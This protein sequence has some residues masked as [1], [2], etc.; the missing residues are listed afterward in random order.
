MNMRS[1]SLRHIS[2]ITLTLA[3][4]LGACGDDAGTFAGVDLAEIRV[5]PRE[6]TFSQVDIGQSDA[7]VVTVENLGGEQLIISDFSWTGSTADFS[8]NGL[9]GL[10]V[11]GNEIATFTINYAPTDEVVDDGVLSIESN[12]GR[13]SV[14]VTTIGQGSAL[15]TEPAAIDLIAD[16]I[17]ETVAQNVRVFNTGNQVYTLT[18][19]SLITGSADFNM[20]LLDAEVPVEI[21]PN[22]EVTVQIIFAPSNGGI[23]EGNLLLEHNADN[24]V[25]GGTIVPI[26]GSLRTPQIQV[27]PNFVEFE[28]VPP[29]ETRIETAVV[30]NV[31][32]STLEIRDIYFDVD[33]DDDFAI[34]AFGGVDY[35][36]DAFEAVSI[37]AGDEL[38]LEL[39]FTPTGGGSGQATAIIFSNDPEFSLFE[40]PMGGRLAAPVL[41]VSPPSLGFGS[42]ANGLSRDM[43]LLIR[44]AGTEELMLDAPSID[45]GG[46]FTLVNADDR[47]DSL[48][49][50][51]TFE[52]L[53][54]FE[55]TAEGALSGQ[56]TVSA[57]NDPVNSPVLVPLSG[58]GA[59]EPFCELTPVPDTINFGLVPRGGEGTGRSAVV[60][61]GPGQCRIN[62]VELEEADFFPIPLPG[63]DDLFSD[64]FS[65]RSTGIAPGTLLG[66]GENFVIEAVYAPVSFTPFSES[67]GDTGSVAI[68]AVDPVSG[69]AVLCGSR[70]LSLNPLAGL[71][72][73][74]CGVN[75]QA[76]SGVADIAAIPG[77]ID[78]G[79]VTRGCNSQ[80]IAVNIYNTGSAPVT[81]NRIALEACTS[82]FRLAGVPAEVSSPDGLVIPSG[83][84]PITV[85]V[86]YTP[87]SLSESA[88]AL[89]IESDGGDTSRLTVPLRGEGTD[90]SEQT[91][92]FVQVSGRKVDLLFVV[93]NSASM[94]E[95]QS[96]LGRNFDNLIGVAETWGTDFQIGVIT[97]EPD[98]EYRGRM[99]GELMGDPRILYAGMP[100][101]ASAF[102]DNINV[103]DSGDGAREAGLSA[104]HQ[105]LSDPLISDIGE[106]GGDCV[107]P[108]AC[109][110]DA[111]GSESRCGGYNR[112]FVREDASL[113][114][115]FVSDEEDQSRATIEFYIDFFRSIKGERNRALFHAS[116]IVG[117][118]GGCT[119]SD[120]DATAGDR[121]IDIADETGGVVGSIC[122]SEFSTSLANIGNRAFGLR[123]QFFLSRI[124]EPGTVTVTRDD[125]REMTGWAFDEASNAVVFS[126]GT[127][128]TPGEEFDVSYR[129]RCF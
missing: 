32:Q 6:V 85:R 65:L 103:G 64:A 18:A 55:P 52:L 38:E 75:L 19:L 53:V 108:Y 79:L 7:R 4:V 100:G 78:F 67:L 86:R 106:C 69:E 119:S 99:P 109:V 23:D 3:A 98:E 34:V 82:E 89:V 9:D 88:C 28:A 8:L 120:G 91:D 113:E 62:S 81:I 61:T 97:S 83:S 27:E 118:R 101:L 105:A 116:A 5:T 87:E 51:E 90:R 124:A 25:S 77:D 49:E 92:H 58:N 76:R 13:A 39:A 41:S 122:D 47:P 20:A 129:A 127:T 11:P 111:T 110:A 115:V 125:G 50:D 54:R 70:R 112:S 60:N 104:A 68:D 37:E 31:G 71:S 59:G 93:D 63:L 1:T 29:D 95:E 22:D 126:E 80:D 17:G 84:A 121:Y 15:R 72:D 2:L 40:L 74:V 73:R 21:G 123:V 14:T 48:A 46:N 66:P 26:T 56:V 107:E 114:L 94:S 102:D 16:A 24:A 42:V 128:P 57:S 43:G 44:N 36:P 96:N 30:S 117:P 12:G 45:G 10:V 35:T 33:S